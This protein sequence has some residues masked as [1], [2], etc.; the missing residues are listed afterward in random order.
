MRSP[1][2]AFSVALNESQTGYMDPLPFTIELVNEGEYYDL[3]THK[4]KAPADGIYYFS[5]SVGMNAEGTA[6]LVLYKNDIPLVNIIRTS[7]NMTG[8][9]T[10]SRDIMMTLHEEDTVHLVNEQ[11]WTARSSQYFETSFSEFRYL[12]EGNQVSRFDTCY[13]QHESNVS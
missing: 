4:F 5:F 1:P 7:T 2:V 12:P 9:D 13:F 6:N 10:T 8:T 11:N 3:E